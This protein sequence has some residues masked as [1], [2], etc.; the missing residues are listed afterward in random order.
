MRGEGRGK[1]KREE[2]RKEKKKRGGKKEKLYNFTLY[3]DIALGVPLSLELASLR[4]ASPSGFIHS[5]H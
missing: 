5:N 1:K 2:G 3:I 4:S